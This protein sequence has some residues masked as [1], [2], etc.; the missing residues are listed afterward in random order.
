MEII[1]SKKR[2]IKPSEIP[3]GDIYCQN[4]KKEK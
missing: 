3:Q 4:K 1:C 2:K